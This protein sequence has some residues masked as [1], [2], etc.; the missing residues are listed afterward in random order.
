MV[1]QL[2]EFQAVTCSL[3]K[4][5]ICTN[6]TDEFRLLARLFGITMWL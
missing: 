5:T 1:D 6:S 4:S 3:H 2:V